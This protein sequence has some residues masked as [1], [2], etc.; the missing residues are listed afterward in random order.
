MVTIDSKTIKGSVNNLRL[1][2]ADILLVHTKKSLWGWIIR[3]GTH[4]YWN[5]ALIV[6]LP[7]T[8]EKC[9]NDT[10]VVDAKT[11]GT[12]EMDHLRKYLTRSNKYDIAV[13]RLDAD[14]FRDNIQS[15]KLEFRERICTIAE[16][17]VFGRYNSR[18]SELTNQTIRQARIILRYLRYKIYGKKKSPKLSWNVRPMQIKAFTCGGFIQWC[19]YKGASQLIKE[20]RLDKSMPKDVVFNPL[21]KKKITPYELLTTTPADIA[22]CNYLSWKYI[23]KGGL[24]RE[25]SNY[26]ETNLCAGVV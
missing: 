4:S 10:L 18:L 13:K 16:K 17:E 21:A 24:I 1:E 7:G 20:H 9:Y 15:Y 5:H 3:H 6:Y 22:H 12:I 23:I 25:V 14:W 2:A 26:K 19:Y 11:G 8:S